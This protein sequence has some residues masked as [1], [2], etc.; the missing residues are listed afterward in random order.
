MEK[1][2]IRCYK[3]SVTVMRFICTLERKRILFPIVD[4]LL[5]SSTSVAANVIEAQSGH[6]RKD[7][8]RFY[9]IA[10]K[11]ANETKYWLCLLRDGAN[12]KSENILPILNE[13]NQISKIIAASII[14]MKASDK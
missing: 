7:F 4:Q 3:F 5:R 2:K 13:A 9:E 14:R 1:V 8:R 10:L 12:I 6:S 11:S